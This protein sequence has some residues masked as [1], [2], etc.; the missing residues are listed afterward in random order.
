MEKVLIGRDAASALEAN[1]S[2]PV[3]VSVLRPHGVMVSVRPR[4]GVNNRRPWEL[5]NVPGLGGEGWDVG[6]RLSLDVVPPHPDVEVELGLPPPPWAGRLP[7][8]GGVVVVHQLLEVRQLLVQILEVVPGVL[9][10]LVHLVLLVLSHDI[11]LYLL[12]YGTMVSIHVPNV[13][14]PLKTELNIL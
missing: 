12:Q 11:T 6:I 9:V 10:G 13:H 4:L 7:V 2:T 5:H 8:Q 3:F 14:C 1:Q